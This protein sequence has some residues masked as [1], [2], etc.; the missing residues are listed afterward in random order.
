MEDPSGLEGGGVDVSAENAAAGLEEEEDFDAF[1]DDTFGVAAAEW[2]EG[3][4]ERLAQLTEEERLALKQSSDF[5][6]LGDDEEDRSGEALEKPTNGELMESAR[7]QLQ[8]GLLLNAKVEKTSPDDPAIVDVGRRGHPELPQFAAADQFSRPPQQQQEFRDPAIMTVVSSAAPQ[9]PMMP[10][11]PPHILQQQSLM[12]AAAAGRPPGGAGGLFPMT[13]PPPPPAAVMHFH[14]PPPPRIGPPMPPMPLPGHP[15]PPNMMGLRPGMVHRPLPPMSAQQAHPQQIY[16]QQQQQQQHQQRQARP[17][18]Q[19][20]A[21]EVELEMLRQQQFQ[22]HRQHQLGH[23][24]YQ[25]RYHG[26]FDDRHHQHRRESYR[27]SDDKNR[28]TFGDDFVDS[29]E[30]EK[31]ANNRRFSHEDDRELMTPGHVHALGIL[32]GARE[33]RQQRQQQPQSTGNPQL[34]L[35]M[36]RRELHDEGWQEEYYSRSA[37]DPY[38][39]LMTPRER[40]W[41]INIQMQ[42]LKWENPFVDDYYFTVYNQEKE[43]KHKDKDE[44]EEDGREFRQLKRSEEGPQLLLQQATA[45][46]SGVDGG[47]GKD[48]YKPVQFSNSLGKLQAVTVKAPRKIIDVGVVNNELNDVTNAQKESR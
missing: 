4:H 18:Y 25:H 36:E 7:R 33:R 22:Q 44:D 15:P 19:K 5:F 11:P 21:Q 13:G 1:N 29:V 12:V 46:L 48:E 14:G 20:T 9:M 39:G 27:S 10:Q 17:A 41:I 30:A 47:L 37:N 42:Q 3:A 2:E 31:R 26:R 35:E 16:L 38:A 6:G 43:A 40:Q 34:D 24:H 32:R 23:H 45:E 8:E 28:E